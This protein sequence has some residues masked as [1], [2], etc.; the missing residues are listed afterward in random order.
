MTHVDV[1]IGNTPIIS[2]EALVFE[3]LQCSLK[4]MYKLALIISCTLP[5]LTVP[6]A[7]H[8]KNAFASRG[9]QQLLTSAR[10]GFFDDISRMFDGFGE[11]KDSKLS[12]A[13]SFET[14]E[15]P[16]CTLIFSIP[17]ESMKRGGLRLLLSLYLISQQNTPEAKTWQAQQSSD[18]EV[19][20]FYKDK[21][22]SL[23]IHLLDEEKKI[24]IYRMGVRP[25]V[26]YMMQESVI[27]HGVLDEFNKV[28]FEGDVTDENRLLVM[29]EDCVQ[30]LRSTL[31]FS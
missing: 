24:K 14:D 26:S 1:G 16:G 23:S 6:F 20:L 11:E 21:S 22:A 9:N 10:Y 31:S 27:L 19:D 12:P 4:D 30:E 5:L 18:T 8:V 13:A 15:Y 29:D 7:V 28:S 17:V 25:S 3:V 2:N